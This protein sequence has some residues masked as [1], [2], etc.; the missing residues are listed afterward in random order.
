MIRLFR[1]PVSIS[2][3]WLEAY[4]KPGMVVVDATAGNGHDTLFLA[5]LVGPKGKVFAFD[6][7][8][9]ALAATG[10]RLRQ[11]GLADRV[12]LIAAGHE[13]LDHYVREAIHA[14]VFNLGYLPGGDK[15]IITRPE[16]TLQALQ[17][18]ME[19]LVPGGL[20]VLT[21][22][23]GHPGG[24]EEWE[25]LKEFI[26]R[27]PREEWDVVQ[28]TFLNRSPSAPFNVGL[29]KIGHDSGGGAF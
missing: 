4:V 29:Q 12:E 27:L 9:A 10:Q 26:L 14:V 18:G 1:D 6:I 3:W 15:T 22:Y 25:S 19:L 17:R 11:H 2:H 5:Q 8:P 28:S 16:T 23:T 13:H 7:Q 20:I 24:G 21:V